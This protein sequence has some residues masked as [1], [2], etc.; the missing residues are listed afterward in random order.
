M[1]RHGEGNRMIE[2]GPVAYNARR[3]S[4]EP[5][6]RVVLR[7]GNQLVFGHHNILGRGDREHVVIKLG[8]SQRERLI[9]NT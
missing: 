7:L 4:R 2:S 6:S 1:A 8:N 3:R 5:G 9:S